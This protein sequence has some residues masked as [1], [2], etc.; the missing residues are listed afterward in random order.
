MQLNRILA[1]DHEVTVDL[2]YESWKN[3]N[4]SILETFP[5]KE[6]LIAFTGGKD[7]SIILEFLIQAGK[8]FSFTFQT[9]A[10]LF[11]V[12]VFTAE[13]SFKLDRYWNARGVKIN[14]HTLDHTDDEFE[15]ARKDGLNP[16]IV[17]HQRK[18]EHFLEFLDRNFKKLDSVVIIVGFTLWDLVSYSLEQLLFSSLSSRT[19]ETSPTIGG[20]KLQDR[21]VQTSQR[22]YPYLVMKEGYSI[23]KPLLKYNDPE[24]V[25]FVQEKQIPLSIVEC[26]Y[27]SYRPKRLFA[28]C[29]KQ[30]NLFFD[31]DKVLSFARDALHLHDMERYRH[32]SKEEFIADIL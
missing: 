28:D 13:E 17:C 19:S 7:C 2:S 30:M 1:K 26:K 23:F 18:R 4:R 25:K 24:I 15:L 20:K 10:F 3:E 27:K 16:C 31:Y 29:Y 12:H 6:V 14:W 11:P 21:F 22:F 5:Q 8:E 9:H 32:Y